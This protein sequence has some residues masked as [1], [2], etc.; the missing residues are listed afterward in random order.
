MSS[1]LRPLVGQLSSVQPPLR[2]VP[3]MFSPWDYSQS[4]LLAL[5]CLS[6]VS[7]FLNFQLH[8]SILFIWYMNTINLL[9]NWTTWVW[10][11]LLDFF[12][13][14]GCSW[15][16]EKWVLWDCMEFCLIGF[17]LFWLFDVLEVLSFVALHGIFLMTLL[18]HWVSFSFFFV[19]WTL[20]DSE[21]GD[22]PV[23]WLVITFILLLIRKMS[24]SVLGCS[25]IENWFLVWILISDWGQGCWKND[26]SQVTICVFLYLP[27][28][29]HCWEDIIIHSNKLQIEHT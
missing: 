23:W 10:M 13:F 17:T 20:V 12:R 16:I 11:L 9:K 5:L 4:T 8:V 21:I 18:L 25:Q 27:D 22:D 7:W 15:W 14:F 29:K 1:F 19:I 24:C 6:L 26:V 3:A 2:K 28:P